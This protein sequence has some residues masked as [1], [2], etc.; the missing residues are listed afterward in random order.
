[1]MAF[2][3]ALG[4]GFDWADLLVRFQRTCAELL[5]DVGVGGSTTSEMRLLCEP[6]DSLPAPRVCALALFLVGIDFL[7]RQQV[8]VQCGLFYRSRI[9]GI[10]VSYLE[11]TVCLTHSQVR[12]ILA[13]PGPLHEIDALLRRGGL[14][15]LTAANQHLM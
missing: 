2:T 6:G 15:A 10:R 1:M 13:L 11:M 4:A 5:L 9:S 12:D 14:A 7:T 3:G 8:R